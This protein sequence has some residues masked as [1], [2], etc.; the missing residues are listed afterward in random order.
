[1]FIP[2]AKLTFMFVFLSSLS[3]ISLFWEKS[4]VSVHISLQDYIQYSCHILL[5]GLLSRVEVV[6]AEI[7][8]NLVMRATR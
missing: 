3:V 5:F 8:E 1:M 4:Q 2:L 7:E 6:N